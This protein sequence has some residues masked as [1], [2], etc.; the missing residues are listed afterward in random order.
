MKSLFHSS[1]YQFD[2][3]QGSCWEA[4]AGDVDQQCKPFAGARNCDI[5]T[6]GGGYTGLSAALAIVL[7]NPHGNV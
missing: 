7:T 3:S 4:V 6:T 5:A 2:T 1:L